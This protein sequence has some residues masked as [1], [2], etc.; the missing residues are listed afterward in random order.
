ML[1]EGADLFPQ[2]SPLKS[3]CPFWGK[4]VIGREQGGGWGEVHSMVYLVDT[5]GRLGFGQSP[6]FTVWEK[7]SRGRGNTIPSQQ[8]N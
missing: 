4:G 3:E 1:G 5:F 6:P 8:E 7:L 2:G